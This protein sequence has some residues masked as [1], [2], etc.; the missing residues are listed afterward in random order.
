M[1]KKLVLESFNRIYPYSN[2]E[3]NVDKNLRGDRNDSIKDIIDPLVGSQSSIVVNNCAAALLLTLNTLSENREV[4][5][6]RGQQVEIGG[7]FRI[8]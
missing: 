8:P 7:S 1:S 2:L 4:I 5:I 6:S 3:F